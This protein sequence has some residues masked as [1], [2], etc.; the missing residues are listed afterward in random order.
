MCV[1][2]KKI[3]DDLEIFE[4]LLFYGIKIHNALLKN[5]DH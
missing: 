1:K 5:E 2:K 4:Y 3:R